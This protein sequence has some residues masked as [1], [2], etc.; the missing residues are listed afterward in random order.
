MFLRQSVYPNT[1]CRITI[2]F[3]R[4]DPRQREL[5]RG[6]RAAFGEYHSDIEALCSPRLV[7]LHLYPG[8]AMGL[9][10]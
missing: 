7:C 10:Q 5:F 9:M 2:L 1:I 6:F 8:G 4:G 3:D